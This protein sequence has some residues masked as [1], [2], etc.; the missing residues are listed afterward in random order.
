MDDIQEAL[1]RSVGDKDFASWESRRAAPNPSRPA[2][3]R[4]SSGR[5]HLTDEARGH[6]DYLK[7]V[8]K[9][10]RTLGNQLNSAK[11]LRI[12]AEGKMDLFNPK[13]IDGF[14]EAVASMASLLDQVLQHKV[15][16][17]KTDPSAFKSSELNNINE[18]QSK[19]SEIN[20][21]FV[22]QYG[23]PMNKQFK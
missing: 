21:Q 9:L 20:K 18:W 23:T 3:S 17:E 22:D 13:F 12:K 16:V 6:D 2:G 1:A 15:T 8:V 14:N 11:E 5:G 4:G 7:E 19:V 10:Q